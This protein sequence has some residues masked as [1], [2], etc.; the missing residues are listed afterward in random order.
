MKII[1]LLQ[2]F[3]MSVTNHSFSD[4]EMDQGE[5]LIKNR[6]AQGTGNVKVRIYPVGTIFARGTGT[7]NSYMNYTAY[8]DPSDHP[9]NNVFITGGEKTIIPFRRCWCSKKF[10]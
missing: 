6:F 10:A 7:N 3:I 4:Q 2:F 5:L 9:A 8:A 1:I